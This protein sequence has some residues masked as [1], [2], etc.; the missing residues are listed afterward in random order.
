MFAHHQMFIFWLICA[1]S[2]YSG[3]VWGVIYQQRHLG[4]FIRTIQQHPLYLTKRLSTPL[5]AGNSGLARERS[6]SSVSETAWP[7]CSYSFGDHG[8]IAVQRA[9]PNCSKCWETLQNFLIRIIFC[10]Q[11]RRC[12]QV[13]TCRIPSMLTFVLHRGFFFGGG[14]ERNVWCLFLF[15]VSWVDPLTW[16]A[17]STLAAARCQLLPLF[18]C[19]FCHTSVFS[20]LRISRKGGRVLGI[21]SFWLSL[22]T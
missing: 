7:S 9:A 3:L 1:C 18:V 11:L 15:T 13:Q 17:R 19:F 20:V 8:C 16:F 22:V 14:G 4:T 21:S 10:V 6:R 5:F 12:V 2:G